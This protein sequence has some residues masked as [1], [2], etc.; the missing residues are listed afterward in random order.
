MRTLQQTFDH[1]A[2]HLLTQNERSKSNDALGL[3]WCQYRSPHGLKCALGVC[4]S[5]KNYRDS[6]EKGRSEYSSVIKAIKKSGWWPEGESHKE[7]IVH[8]NRL[9]DI[10]DR[11]SPEMWRDSL[12]EYANIFGLSDAAIVSH[13]EEA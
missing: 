10:H 9:Q 3:E 8:F 7:V 13:K 6:F 2:L 11:E 12:L 1:I 4:I 5:D